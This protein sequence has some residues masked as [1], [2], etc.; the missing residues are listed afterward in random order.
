MDDDRMDEERIDPEVTEMLRGQYNPPPETPREA[1]WAVIQAGLGR[2]ATVRA[3]EEARARRA[4]SGRRPFAWAVAAAAVLILGIGIG[5]MSAP[6]QAATTAPGVATTT[7]TAM[8]T[9]PDRTVLRAAA[10]DH[11]DRTEALLTVVR[12]DARDGR[13]DPTMRTWARGL[14]TQTRL[15]LD[16]PGTGEPAM[17]ELLEDLE[18]VLAQIV[19]VAEVEGVDQA[20]ARNEMNLALRGLDDRDVLPRIQAVVPAGSGLAGT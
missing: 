9:T 12:A 8:P 19:R 11:L 13:V 10:M 14:L 18:L 5:R 15:L 7:P 4:D 2:G 1:M 3:I 17:R 20:R 16:A 6:R